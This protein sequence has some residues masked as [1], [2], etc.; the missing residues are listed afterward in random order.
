M[1]RFFRTIIQREDVDPKG[2]VSGKEM[3]LFRH[4]ASVSSKPFDVNLRT[5]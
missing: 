4:L 5:N 2:K 3:E 1:L